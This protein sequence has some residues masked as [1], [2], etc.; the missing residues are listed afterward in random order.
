VPICVGRP[1]LPPVQATTKGLLYAPSRCHFE[2]RHECRDATQRGEICDGSFGQPYREI[3]QVLGDRGRTLIEGDRP[4]CNVILRHM[5]LTYT[6][7]HGKR[8]CSISVLLIVVIGA[9]FE[10]PGCSFERDPTCGPSR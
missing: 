2:I 10:E 8:S 7:G 6:V 9:T 5:S 1:Q 4:L 3:G